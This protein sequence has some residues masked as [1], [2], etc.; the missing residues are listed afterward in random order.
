MLVSHRFRFIF[1]KT[2]K[3]ASSSLYAAFRDIVLEHD[4]P[5][6][7]DWSVRRQL[8]R[9]K[10]D[11]GSV[12]FSGR[13]G[14]FRRRLPRLSGLHRHGYASDLRA[15]L[16]PEIFD[17]YTVIT[18]ERNPWDRQ[19]SLFA[20][21]SAKDEKPS[22]TDFAAAMRS[23]LYNLLHHNRLR[24]W[25]IYSIDDRVCAH[26][27]IRFENLHDDFR[28]AI[29]DLGLDP[30]RHV[31]PHRRGGNR[32]DAGRYRDLYTDEVRDLVGR[33]YRREIEHFGYEF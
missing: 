10:V 2:E 13:S 25:E 19:V 26:H 32:S 30:D 8:L 6:P 3:T 9:Q 17:R 15:F 4:K 22:G 24:N 1:L 16:G 5:F 12:S 29:K 7:A 33:W 11:L 31:L 27:V 18:S 20:H 14:A 28:A 21:R 23:P